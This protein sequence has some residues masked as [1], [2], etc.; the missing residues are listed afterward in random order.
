[1]R[2]TKSL[3]ISACFFVLMCSAGYAVQTIDGSGGPITVELNSSGESG[4]VSFINQATG[5]CTLSVLGD[6]TI[7]SDNNAAGI[8]TDANLLGNV[9]FNQASGTVNVNG[10]VGDSLFYLDNIQIGDGNV[11][12]SD[13]VFCKTLTFSGG[14]KAILNRDLFLG[15]GGVVFNAFGILEIK[16]N[17][18]AT[19]A[20]GNSTATGQLHL[21]IDSIVNGNVA[22]QTIAFVASSNPDLRAGIIN[23]NMTAAFIDA[24][25]GGINVFGDVALAGARISVNNGIAIVPL[26][27]Y[28]NAT[29]TSPIYVDWKFPFDQAPRGPTNGQ[30]VFANSGT[31]GADIIVTSNDWRVYFS[32][33]NTNGIITVTGYLTSPPANP[34]FESAWWIDDTPYY[35]DPFYKLLKVAYEHPGSDLD[36]IE[37]QLVSPTYQG[38]VDYLY[39]LYPAPALVGVARES[40]NTTKQ[41]QRIYLEHLQRDRSLC[42]RQKL[43]GPEDECV[44]QCKGLK[45]WADGFQYH[46]KRNNQR[47]GKGYQANTS[48]AAIG[49]EQP[50]N[51]FYRCGGGLGYA[52]SSIRKARLNE[53][54]RPNHTHVHQCEGTFYST[55]D[56]A[57]WFTDMG[58]SFAWNHYEGKRHINI[59]SINR[60]AR[61]EYNGT[62]YSTFIDTGYQYCT[63]RFEITP[64][65]SLIYSYLHIN[66]HKE[67][68]AKTLNLRFK[69]QNYQFLES[70]LGFK[71]AYDYKTYW[72]FFIPEIRAMWLYD[73]FRE[74]V[75]VKASYSELGAAVGSFRNKGPHTDRNTLNVGG[76]LTFLRNSCW[77]MILDYDYEI[78]N[79]YYDQQGLIE[80]SYVF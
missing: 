41:F 33:Q 56:K 40:F 23:G 73:F 21:G 43:C 46:G 30:A 42:V 29:Y 51:E 47:S 53:E 80:F 55:F 52:Y 66:S 13:R 50:I 77:S 19:G 70:S 11:N 6:T 64:I 32:G 18:V 12:F 24:G 35:K 62:E 71:T 65:A 38:Y 3:I 44:D 54:T 9:N 60:T 67:T 39:Q 25:N 72:G 76:S 17:A 45:V 1:M 48:G 26:I 20:I 7:N 16:D 8:S 5:E 34:S 68:G 10:K 74:S 37:G 36:F 27:V 28:G 57:H 31:S 61:S 15:S 78:S 58:L 75:N 59:K 4:G 2:S 69:G 79:H 63:N 22:V 49:A 14:A